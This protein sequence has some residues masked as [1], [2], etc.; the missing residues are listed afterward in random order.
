VYGL[1]SA[2][3]RSTKVK[4][5]DVMPCGSDGIRSMTSRFG[6]P[7]EHRIYGS[8]FPILRGNEM[9]I[10]FFRDKN[11]VFNSFALSSKLKWKIHVK[12]VNLP[13][14]MQLFLY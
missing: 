14:Y 9:R 13:L 11:D 5:G 2:W 1:E 8:I 6:I 12:M 10:Y 4:T 3:T 7:L